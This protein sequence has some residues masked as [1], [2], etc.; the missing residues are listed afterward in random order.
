MTLSTIASGHGRRAGRL[1]G[2]ALLVGAALIAAPAAAQP[3]AEQERQARELFDQERYAEATTRLRAILTAEPKNRTASVLLPF[4]LARQGDTAGAI[5]EARRGLE[6]A[7]GNVNLQLLLAGLLSQVEAGRPEA[8]ARFQAIVDRDPDNQVARI[9]LAEALRG[10]GR[11]LEAIN[12]FT[13]LSDRAPNDP[14]FAVRL[15]QLYGSLGDLDRARFHF[16]RAY[17]LDPKNPDAVRSLALLNDV[18][19]RAPEAL[20]YYRELLALYPSDVSAQMAAREGEDRLAEPG[21]PV[22]L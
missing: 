6:V 16:E 21:F 20:R 7:P 19:D 8:L 3:V 13:L 15:G 9:G 22:P 18:G 10:A 4:A 11:V 2:L 14:R 1:M 5:A 12:H 17:K